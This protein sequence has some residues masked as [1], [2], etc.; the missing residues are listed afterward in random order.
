M[1]YRTHYL[2]DF[3]KTFVAVVVVVVVVVVCTG[4]FGVC[5]LAE[6]MLPY[7]RRCP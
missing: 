2:F 5:V 4:I 1:R 6:P 3:L 7:A